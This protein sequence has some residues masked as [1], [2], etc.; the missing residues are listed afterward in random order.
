MVIFFNNG[1]TTMTFKIWNTLDILGVHAQDCNC[2]LSW[3]ISTGCRMFCGGQNAHLF[4]QNWIH[5]KNFKLYQQ[6]EKENHTNCKNWLP[7]VLKTLDRENQITMKKTVL[8]RMLSA[9]CQQSFSEINQ[10]PREA[11]QYIFISFIS[12]DHLP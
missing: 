11:S 5:E 9:Q 4:S 3:N 2:V 10:F 12:F 6:R 1:S 7:Q 8:H